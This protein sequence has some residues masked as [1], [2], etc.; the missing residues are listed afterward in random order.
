M[1]KTNKLFERFL[2]RLIHTY[3]YIHRNDDEEEGEEEEYE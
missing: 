1:L 3:I 2:K